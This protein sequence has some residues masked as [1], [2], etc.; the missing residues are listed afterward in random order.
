METNKYK[1]NRNIRNLRWSPSSDE[2]VA[3]ALGVSL[4]G[5]DLARGKF[6]RYSFDITGQVLTPYGS[7]LTRWF[8][9]PGNINNVVEVGSLARHY[10]HS[11]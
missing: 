5:V 3:Q 11:G 10:G 8:R 2:C 4:K 9:M 7:R 6:L 1:E